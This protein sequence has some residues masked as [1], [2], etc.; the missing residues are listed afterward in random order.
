MTR[1]CA[2]CFL[3][4]LLGSLAGCQLISKENLASTTPQNEPRSANPTYEIRNSLQRSMST[5]G[6]LM[7]GLM[8]LQYLI[9]LRGYTSRSAS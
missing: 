7:S 1:S 3:L 6:F 2:V 9:I 8:T 4:G 5:T